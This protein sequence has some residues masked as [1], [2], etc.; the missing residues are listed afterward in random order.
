MNKLL[1]ALL[2]FSLSA[3]AGQKVDRIIA[4]VNSEPIL[5]SDVVD[6]VK[7]SK[8]RGLLDDLLIP[9]GDLS[10]IQSDSKKQ[11]QYLVS[12]KI[13]DSEI[14]R[15]NMNVTDERVEQEIRDT[16]KKS[17][18]PRSDLMKM[19]QNQGME[20]ATYKNVIKQK[21]E[22]NSLFETEI[23][24]KLRITDDEAFS[25]YQKRNPKAKSRVYE[26]GISHIL[27]N[28]KKGGPE[29]ALERAESALQKIEAG[30]KFELVAE[31]TSE[32]SRFSNGGFLGTF[33][34]GEFT[35]E[36]ESA[37]QNLEEG[38]V[39]KVVQSKT[40]FHILKLTSK[41]V[42]PDP[43]FEREK[44]R[45]KAALFDVNFKRQLKTWLDTKREDA[46]VKYNE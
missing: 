35:P 33:K 21:I 3:T 32:D 9:S 4:V 2:F 37:V 12:E 34:S 25:E 31:Q 22:R 36:F 24:S 26:Y 27:F 39:S 29:K 41:K 18:M 40:G 42:V 20:F 17:G 15:L 44:E 16:V 28:P 13:L 30:Q 46:S 43:Q 14:K 10:N 45:I 38:N 23:V 6:L 7:R 19:L 5:Q 11:I 8:Q 1:F